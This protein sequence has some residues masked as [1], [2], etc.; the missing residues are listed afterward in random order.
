MSPS[1]R[2]YD[3]VNYYGSLVYL[4]YI[5]LRPPSWVES[6]YRSMTTPNLIQSFGVGLLSSYHAPKTS[7]DSCHPVSWCFGSRCGS[8]ESFRSTGFS[9]PHSALR[10]RL[11]NV[12][13]IYCS[14]SWTGCFFFINNSSK[15]RWVFRLVGTAASIYQSRSRVS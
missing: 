1:I 12:C 14:F 6:S 5:P 13:F 11:S 8:S 10:G 4:Q 15:W 2:Q 7:C 9:A 3:Q